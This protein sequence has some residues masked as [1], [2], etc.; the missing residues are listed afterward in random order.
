MAHEFSQG[1]DLPFVRVVG[2]DVKRVFAMPRLKNGLVRVPAAFHPLPDFRPASEQAL[3]DALEGRPPSGSGLAQFDPLKGPFSIHAA[4]ANAWVQSLDFLRDIKTAAIGPTKL[5]P[6][7]VTDWLVHAARDLDK[8]APLF[9]VGIET[10]TK[11]DRLIWRSRRI[12]NCLSHVLPIV[13]KLE[14]T[15]QSDF[16]RILIG[17]IAKIGAPTQTLWAGLKDGFDPLSPRAIW[18]RAVAILGVEAAFSGFL[19]QVLVEK[20]KESINAA[21]Q[22]DGLIIGGSIV[23]TMSACAD[24]CMLARIP[25]V[26]PT[27]SSIRKALASLRY[28]D[29]KLVT[30]GAGVADYSHLL[31]AVLGPGDW[32]PGA[33]FVDS[34]IARASTSRTTIWIR[35]P[36]AGRGW[37]AACEV[38]VGGAPLLTSVSGNPSA[39]RFLSSIDV[40][41]ARCRR[42]DEPEW[43]VLE[44]SATLT[45]SGKQ[46]IS[47]RQIRVAQ[48]GR[49]IEGEDIF[50]PAGNRLE[51]SPLS[52]PQ[53]DIGGHEILFCI[54]QTASC[55]L[56][57]DRKSALIVTSEQQ[58]WRFR[59]LGMD[60]D[61]QMSSVD[62]QSTVRPSKQHIIICRH[63]GGLSKSDFKATWQ[64]VP[65]E[66]K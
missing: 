47:I 50:R 27:L 28:Q 32:K 33:V 31:T 35:A 15:T 48:N 7:W 30:F 29:G 34:G 49:K 55:T 51:T 19:Q 58:A 5:T 1:Q 11:T 23:G 42:R 18:L 20:S 25:A 4:Q 38:E 62:N 13:S 60:I 53:R 52:D 12:L 9:G 61:V 37:G 2:V 40:T 56:S 36:Q 8:P 64:L 22:K 14:P 65:E 10:S 57:N 44:A 3:A 59:L 39:M 43:L 26:E 66:L 24:L 54:P 45:I 63:S 16:W 6:I 21:I 41:Q 17:D 46:F